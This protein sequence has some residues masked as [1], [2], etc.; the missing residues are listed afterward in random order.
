LQGKWELTQAIGKEKGP[1]WHQERGKGG[2]PGGSLFAQK[3][4]TS[5]AHFSIF[6]CSLPIRN[7]DRGWAVGGGRGSLRKRSKKN[8]AKNN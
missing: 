7:G 4:K 8:R 5:P 6:C 2:V 1:G 3:G